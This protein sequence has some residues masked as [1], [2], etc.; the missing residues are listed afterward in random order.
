MQHSIA[1]RYA[2]WPAARFAR[3]AGLGRERRLGLKSGLRFQRAT[4]HVVIARSSQGGLHMNGWRPVTPLPRTLPSS[5]IV[6]VAV[7]YR[8]AGS[9]RPA[10]DRRACLAPASWR[11]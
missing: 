11:G 1:A 7:T 3:P 2:T 6:R 10:A 5:G 4:T 9:A 8:W